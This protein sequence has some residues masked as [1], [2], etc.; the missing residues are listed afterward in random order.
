MTADVA[1]AFP[2]DD[3]F[4]PTMLA[5]FTWF[6]AQ[7]Y[8]CSSTCGWSTFQ[9]ALASDAS[10]RSYVTVSGRCRFKTNN[11]ANQV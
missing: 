1:A 3:A 2:A 7:L 8:W 9:V 10:G 5:V 6:G 11:K 4:S